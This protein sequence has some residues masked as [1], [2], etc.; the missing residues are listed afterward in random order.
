MR[1]T[2]LRVVAEV[3]ELDVLEQVFVG[4]FVVLYFGCYIFRV[5]CS[6]RKSEHF[7]LTCCVEAFVF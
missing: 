5:L 1:K 3:A 2:V 7:R 4:R 6:R